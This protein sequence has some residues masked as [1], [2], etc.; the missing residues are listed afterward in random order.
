MSDEDSDEGDRESFKMWHTS[1]NGG[2]VG[3]LFYF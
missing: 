3:Y 2:L 1:E